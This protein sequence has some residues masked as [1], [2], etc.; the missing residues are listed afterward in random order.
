[1]DVLLRLFQ[2]SSRHNA[3]SSCSH[4]S[5]LRLSVARE[6]NYSVRFLY[7]LEYFQLIQ[8]D[9]KPNRGSREFCDRVL[10]LPVEDQ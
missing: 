7:N 2:G 3:F 5:I 4:K 8:R 9:N 6:H 10:S 1:M